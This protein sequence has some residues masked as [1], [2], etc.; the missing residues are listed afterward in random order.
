MRGR[1]GGRAGQTGVGRTGSQYN[2]FFWE[3]VGGRACT[4]FGKVGCCVLLAGLIYPQAQIVLTT[5]RTC[6]NALDWGIAGISHNV[7]HAVVR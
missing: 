2:I 4:T 3:G 7:P 6:G 1:A 5:K